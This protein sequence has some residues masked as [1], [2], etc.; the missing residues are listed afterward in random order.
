MSSPAAGVKP[1][2]QART[3]KGHEGNLLQRDRCP[4]DGPAPAAPSLV[5]RPLPDFPSRS[6]RAAGPRPGSL[7][8]TVV[9]ITGILARHPEL[10]TRR[11][12]DEP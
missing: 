1:E 7:A 3:G 8:A 2:R 12:V 9:E 11:S 10:D 5:S 4:V 6:G